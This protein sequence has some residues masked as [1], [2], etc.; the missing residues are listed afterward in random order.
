MVLLILVSRPVDM[1]TEY[2]CREKQVDVWRCAIGGMRRA[3]IV[4]SKN[5]YGLH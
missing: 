3:G 1:W 2:P 5:M 4:V